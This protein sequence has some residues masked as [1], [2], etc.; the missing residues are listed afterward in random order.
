[1]TYLETI[2]ENITIFKFWASFF[3][4]LKKQGKEIAHIILEN[5]LV[6]FQLIHEGL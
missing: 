6:V 4:N 2:G 3:L 5:A 1:M